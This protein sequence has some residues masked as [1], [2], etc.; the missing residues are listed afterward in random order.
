MPVQL[1][2]GI[3]ERTVSCEATLNSVCVL[4]LY[5]IVS[6][7]TG[8]YLCQSIG[9]KQKQMVLKT[10]SAI[11]VILPMGLVMGLFFPTGMKLVKT[12]NSTE[13]PWYWALNGIWGVLSS[14]VAVFTSIYIS[15]SLNFTI[16]AICYGLLPLCI[17]GL[18]RAQRVPTARRPAL[19]TV[20]EQPATVSS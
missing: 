10:L 4:S 19:G 20:T 11:L 1:E 14:A 2:T 15:V 5:L 17:I 3:R 9:K 6:V 7:Y 12:A 8:A 18:V 16:G 13:A